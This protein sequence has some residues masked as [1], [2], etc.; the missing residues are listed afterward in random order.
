VLQARATV[1]NREV[2]RLPWRTPTGRL[3]RAWSI[4]DAGHPA[5]LDCGG[6]GSDRQRSPQRP[7]RRARKR[8]TGTVGQCPPPRTATVR[9]GGQGTSERVACTG[10]VG[11]TRSGAPAL[12]DHQTGWGAGPLH[13]TLLQVLD[14][15][16]A[17]YRS[18]KSTAI[19]ISA[20]PH[21]RPLTGQFPG[22]HGRPELAGQRPWNPNTSG[23]IV[24]GRSSTLTGRPTSSGEEVRE[25]LPL[26][27]PNLHKFENMDSGQ[28]RLW[29]CEHPSGLRRPRDMVGSGAGQPGLSS[30]QNR[31]I[32]MYA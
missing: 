27:F 4:D 31:S 14:R 12:P 10:G 23:L 32:A 19:A 16:A 18:C 3:G 15:P 21:E 29:C 22:G 24:V 17:W 7:R 6:E 8:A 25:G 13:L 28:T 26:P 30:V 2:E 1:P 9:R 5:W 20:R 11:R